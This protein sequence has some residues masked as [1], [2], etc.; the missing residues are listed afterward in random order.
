MPERRARF[1]DS[2]IRPSRKRGVLKLDVSLRLESARE[3]NPGPVPAC[4][5]VEN[6]LGPRAPRPRPQQPP[7][8]PSAD[9]RNQYPKRPRSRRAPRRGWGRTPPPGLAD[10]AEH[11]RFGLDAYEAACLPGFSRQTQPVPSGP[12]PLPLEPPRSDFTV[13]VGPGEGVLQ[14]RWV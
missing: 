11:M 13:I 12:A 14:L 10:G 7:P 8:G 3:L 1:F 9:V 6:A 5:E 4:A 2:E